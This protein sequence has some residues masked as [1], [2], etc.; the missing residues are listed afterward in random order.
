[1]DPLSISAS[2]AGLIALTQTILGVLS[3]AKEWS[4]E[5]RALELEIKGLN[6]V[7]RSLESITGSLEMQSEDASGLFWPQ[8]VLIVDALKTLLTQLDCCRNM[9]EEANAEL[10]P[11]RKS[12]DSSSS[13][14]LKR[15]KYALKKQGLDAAFNRVQWGKGTLNT[16]MLTLQ[17][18]EQNCMSLNQS[19]IC[20]ENTTRGPE[21]AM[22]GIH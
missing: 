12:K 10:Y 19:L 22:R 6:E 15:A 13:N 11:L 8:L 21:V 14:A 17:L 18:H 5:V 20:S 9:L 4:K 16:A 1:M 3:N 2:I 7:I